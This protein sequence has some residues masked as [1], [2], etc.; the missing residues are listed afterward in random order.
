MTPQIRRATG[1][2]R[3][4]LMATLMTVVTLFDVTSHPSVQ[5][6]RHPMAFDA[7]GE[8]DL[9]EEGVLVNP[10]SQISVHRTPDA[11]FVQVMNGEVLLRMPKGI[12]RHVV[13]T[14]AH[15]RISNVEASVCVK[16]E[17]D[18]TFVVILEGAARVGTLDL[19]DE[20][21]VVSEMTLRAGDRVEVSRGG[22]GVMFRIGSGRS[23]GEAR[24]CL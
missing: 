24:P 17:S 15:A 16:V 14:A 21:H 7:P 5:T 10:R 23:G 1:S 18:R 3:K 22:G 20:S 19:D 2:I 12:E 4:H 11:L 6:Y 13:V 9:R 8:I